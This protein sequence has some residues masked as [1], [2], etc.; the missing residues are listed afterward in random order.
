MVSNNLLYSK[1][2]EFLERF[3]EDIWNSLWTTLRIT[4][5]A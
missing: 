5:V 2:Y 4:A 3:I 1:G